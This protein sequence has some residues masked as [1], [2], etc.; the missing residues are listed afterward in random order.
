M[1]NHP[2]RGTR[3]PKSKWNTCSEHGHQRRRDTWAYST[4]TTNVSKTRGTESHWSMEVTQDSSGL[5]AQR[6]SVSEDTL[7]VYKMKGFPWWQVHIRTYWYREHLRSYPRVQIGQEHSVPWSVTQDL[8]AS[9]T[10]SWT[11]IKYCLLLPWIFLITLNL[12]S[13]SLPKSTLANVFWSV[14][15]RQRN[16]HTHQCGFW[17]Q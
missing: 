11:P 12:T 16:R 5:A 7:Q 9:T 15:Q 13:C 14:T 17:A 6:T 10:A 2:S 1:L 4:R 3:F 8:E